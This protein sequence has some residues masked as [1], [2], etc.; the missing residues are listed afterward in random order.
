MYGFLLIDKPAGITSHDVVDKLRRITGI[1]KIGHAGTLDP[2]ATGLLL[3]AIGREA[4]REISGFVGLDKVYEGRFH[5]RR[6]G[7]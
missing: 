3:M 1:K 2:F 7:V 5:P 6:R 4:T